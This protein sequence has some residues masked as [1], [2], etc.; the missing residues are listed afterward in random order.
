VRT[1]VSLPGIGQAPANWSP[2]DR[3]VP[4]PGGVGTGDG[5]DEL[6]VVDGP[7]RELTHF[8]TTLAPYFGL[9]QILDR[10]GG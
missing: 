3:P 6:D 7:I 10:A 8:E 2:G 4:A 1:R 5:S 9:P